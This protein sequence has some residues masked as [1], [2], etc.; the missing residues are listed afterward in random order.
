M[1]N[2]IQPPAV[3]PIFIPLEFWFCKTK[4]NWN[5]SNVNMEKKEDCQLCYDKLCN[6]QTHCCGQKFC[7][8]CITK[9][10]KKARTCPMCREYF[11]FIID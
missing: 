6:I 2:S 10:Y 5:W 8:D 9:W 4:M 11:F 7:E 1:D 3:E